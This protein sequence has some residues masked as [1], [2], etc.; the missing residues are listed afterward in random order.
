[1][2]ENFFRKPEEVGRQSPEL[3]KE[4]GELMDD[5]KEQLEN[6]TN[7]LESYFGEKKLPD[8]LQENLVLLRRKIRSKIEEKEYLDD[9]GGLENE[10]AQLSIKINKWNE[11]KSGEF[12]FDNIKEVRIQKS[13]NS[14]P[15]RL[16]VIF[17]GDRIETVDELNSELF[18][19]LLDYYESYKHVRNAY[20]FRAN[21]IKTRE[22]IVF[23]NEMRKLNFYKEQEKKDVFKE[24]LRE[25]YK[26]IDFSGDEFDTLIEFC[27]LSALE[28]IEI[29][30]LKSWQKA[31]QTIKTFTKGERSKYLFWSMA[32]ILPAVAKTYAP[33]YF[34]DAFD[35]KHSEEI[36]IYLAKFGLLTT[37]GSAGELFIN[38]S[39]NKMSRGNLNKEGGMAETTSQNIAE[40]PGDELK[41]F[42][43]R[44]MK[45]KAKNALSE[46]NYL[47]KSLGFDVLPAFSALATSAVVLGMRDPK[48][49][50]ISGGLALGSIGIAKFME[51]K[52]KFYD[53]IRKTK[54]RQIETEKKIEELLNAHME[55]IISGEKDNFQKNLEHLLGE[56]YAAQIAK[57]EVDQFRNAIYEAIKNLSFYAMGV[58]T[59]MLGNFRVDNF[60]ALI[61]QSGIIQQSLNQFGRIS[62][63]LVEA[64]RDI[65][66]AELMF[67]GYANE[68][69]GKEKVRV[70]AS[71]VQ[72][73]DL[74]FSNVSLVSGRKAFFKKADFTIPA[75]S[76]TYLDGESGSG[77]STLIKL[78]TGYYAPTQGEVKFGDTPLDDVQRSGQD[79]IYKKFSYLPQFP[80][81]FERSVKDN[82]LFGIDPKIAK[83]VSNDEIKKILRE[84]RLSG[85]F[86]S[87][88]EKMSFGRGED[89][90]ASGGEASRL[91]LARVIMQIRY[92]KS[93]ILLLDEPTAS[94]DPRTKKLIVEVLKKE[95]A[96]NLDMTFIVISHD[97]EFVSMLEFDKTIK[98]SN[99][100]ALENND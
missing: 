58:G 37:L 77:K 28:G 5:K 42:G 50:A 16:H 89:S 19:E 72:G 11:I 64:V 75:G 6:F 60:V 27:D 32:L 66:E 90:K 73:S 36:A 79:S 70:G 78:M 22:N 45:V 55:I 46:Y 34:A 81:I 26:D 71:A 98:I 53:K 87:I 15:R 69:E 21:V 51:K 44:E 47:Y 80:T 95:K 30:E 14:E 41:D 52:M 29:H 82:L 96:E 63:R 25:K 39:F 13:E 48:L 65:K 4:R 91:G 35:P 7:L 57:Q 74:T 31:Y 94:V 100:T 38:R 99:S 17:E 88:H 85:R 12:D 8:E 56:E 93:K 62:S 61:M 1:M 9:L 49:V 92:N 43:N 23:E 76:M 97:T 20:H 18:E 24:R 33:A 84:V 59:Q 10:I 40:F 68:E 67:N 86:T 54:D 2:H 3:V 83:D